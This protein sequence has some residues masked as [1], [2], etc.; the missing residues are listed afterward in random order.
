M[1]G[2]SANAF[3]SQWNIGLCQR[4]I[5]IGYRNKGILLERY[6]YFLTGISQDLRLVFHNGFHHEK[7]RIL[8]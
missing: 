2:P 8:F 4:A 6:K 5:I 1:P 3:V 7:G